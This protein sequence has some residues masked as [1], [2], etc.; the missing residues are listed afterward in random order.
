MMRHHKPDAVGAEFSSAER[1]RASLLAHRVRM[2]RGHGAVSLKR[3]SVFS[4]SAQSR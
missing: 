3:L 4:C 2:G 1:R